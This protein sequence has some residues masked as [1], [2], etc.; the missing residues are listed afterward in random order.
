MSFRWNF[1]SSLSVNFPMN[2]PAKFPTRFRWYYFLPAAFFASYLLIS[3]GVPVL[4][5]LLGCSLVA[6]LTWRVLSR[7]S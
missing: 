3:R 7:P 1:F 6:F 5:V 4:P 2:L